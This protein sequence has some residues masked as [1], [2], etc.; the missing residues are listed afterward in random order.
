MK[1]ENNI[2]LKL[3]ELLGV[4]LFRKMAFVVRDF[5]VLVFTFWWKKEKRHELLYGKPSNYIIGKDGDILENMKKFKGS[6]L[7]NAIIHI[8]CILIAMPSILDIIN[9]IG[10]T[11]LIIQTSLYIILNL[12]CIM[13]QRYNHIKINRVIKK[14]ESR[15]VKKKNIIF[16]EIKKDYDINKVDYKLYDKKYNGK[17][18]TCDDFLQI[19]TLEQLKNYREFLGNIDKCSYTYIH[20]KKGKTL[21]LELNRTKILN[22]NK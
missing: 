16:E 19:A 6:L 22:K 13:L 7:T 4:K 9:G 11:F 5:L 8:I 21:K 12:Y 3:Y 17:M 2:E 15:E 1:K 18:I 10:S 20:L 14:L